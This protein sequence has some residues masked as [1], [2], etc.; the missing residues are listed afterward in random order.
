MPPALA[1]CVDDPA[2]E[3]QILLTRIRR[4][5]SGGIATTHDQYGWTPRRWFPAMSMV[6]LPTALIAAEELSRRGLG[7]DVQLAP[8][9]PVLSGEWP[10]DEPAAEPVARSL[11]RIFTVSENVPH[12]RLYDFIGPGAIQARL[13][14]L[15]YPDA[16]VV[17]RVGAPVGDGRNTRSG[18]LLDASGD[19]IATWPA[20]R[21]DT[22]AFPYGR[23]LAGRGWMED[24][25][26]VTPGPHDFGH[27]NFVPLADLHGMLLALALPAAVAPSRRWAIAEPMRGQLL[28]IMAMMP[29]DCTDPVY[30]DDASRDGLARFLALGGSHD[31]KPASLRLTGKVGEAYGYLGDTEYVQDL[32]GGAEFLLSAV[33]CVNADGIFN[34]D[35]YEYDEVGIPFLGA[36]GR[37]VLEDERDRRGRRDPA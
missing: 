33:I 34:D 3:V 2:H 14:A 22:L 37:A 30:R 7:L 28:R 4:D 23:A 36:L 21:F 17:N 29:R 11:R 6:K 31:D 19:T 16:R 9:P 15:G 26:R 35:K 18:R 13:A 25:G 5:A 27:G 24:D 32:D 10:A 20:R 8:D 12:N 1:A